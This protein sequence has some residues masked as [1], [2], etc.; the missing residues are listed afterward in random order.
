MT[1]EAIDQLSGEMFSYQLSTSPLYAAQLGYPGFIDKLPDN[2][3]SGRQ[4][5]KSQLEGI[6]ARVRQVDP[7]VLDPETRVTHT[8]LLRQINDQILT[9]DARAD[10]YT[11]SPTAQTGLAATVILSFP[12]TMLRTVDDAEAYLRRCSLVPGWLEQAKENLR[13]G[14]ESGRTP[15]RLQTEAAIE[16]LTAYLDTPVTDD[17]L[18]GV[19]LPL[20]V[21]DA[22]TDRLMAVVRDE[23]RPAMSAYRDYLVNAVLPGARDNDHPGIA[24]LPNGVELYSKLIAQHT[25]TDRTAEE[26]HQ[27]GLDLV[28]DLIEEMRELGE[29]VLGTADF[30][31]IKQ[32][33]RADKD[34]FFTTPQ[35]ILGA[36]SDALNRAQ[37][38][39]PAWIGRLPEVGCQVLPM[40][41][42]EVENGVLGYYQWP[43]QDGSRP[44]TYWVNTYKP[45]TRPRFE[46]Q[47]LAFHESVP[48]HHTQL[49]LSQELAEQNDFRRHAR[50]NAFSEGWALYT[51]RL[52]DEMGL[53]TQNI[54]R[55]GMISFDFWRATRLVV[56]TGMHAMGWSRDRAVKYMFDNSALTLKNIENEV[57]RYIS[58]PGQALAYMHGRLEIRRL[59][60]LARQRLGSAFVLRDFHTELLSHGSLPLSVLAEV[61][62]RWIQEREPGNSA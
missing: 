27:T 11:V 31:A 49:A 38:A 15:V 42:Y 29:R 56:D 25:T 22:W 45:N 53:Y 37:Q 51:E 1:R 34:L 50:V 8:M 35:E 2:S 43:S 48:G 9:I 10:D 36:A 19:S 61:M 12:K 28:A 4:A 54:Y 52:C 5:R 41:A 30:D 23:V 62:E 21:T 59:R 55:L 40:N 3:E 14:R 18:L 57:D 17:P 39:L 44:G 6:A 26:I 47:V 7:E 60:D 13:S 20:A 58:W 33:L 24:N 32:R 16:Q 46:S